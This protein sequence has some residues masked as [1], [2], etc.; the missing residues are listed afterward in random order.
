MCSSERA[1]IGNNCKILQNVTIGG[2]SR[3][4][5]PVI[6]DNVLIGAGATIIGNVTIGN[7]A[8]IGAMSLILDDVPANA[9][10]VANKGKVLEKNK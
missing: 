4:E 6:K 3:G 10:I 8:K 2:N 1:I 5:T 9:I 7:N